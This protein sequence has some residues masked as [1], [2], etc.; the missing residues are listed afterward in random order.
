MTKEMLSPINNQKNT[1]LQTVRVKNST[2]YYNKQLL[3]TGAFADCTVTCR[4]RSWPAHRNVL[5]PRCDF[6]KCCFDG[7]FTEGQTRVIVMEDDDPV[8]VDG[9]LFY[10]YTLDYPVEL[11]QRLLGTETSS[12]SDSGIEDEETTGQDAKVYWS[13]D[14]SMYTIADKYGLTELREMAENALLGKAD[15]AGKEQQLLTNMDGFVAL[16]EDLYGLGETSDQMSQLRTQ[17]VSSTCEAITH[18]V[19]DQRISTLIS[20]VPEF[21][22]DLVEAIGKKRDERRMVQR[23]EDKR[24][25]AARVRICHV[26]MNEESDWED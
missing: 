20:D 15:L 4:G 10:L 17:I 24:Q 25:E 23:E 3:R 1:S 6:F 14:L 19:R 16:L 2:Y 22:V 12:G 9:M 26:P 8:A 21:A 11:Y 5:S 7:R 18:H 13:F